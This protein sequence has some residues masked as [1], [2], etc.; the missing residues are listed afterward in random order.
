MIT[1]VDGQSIRSFDELLIYIAMQAKPGQK[2]TL[3]ILRNSSSQ[4]IDV[5]L[6]TR[7]EGLG[8]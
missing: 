2:V 5:Q 1:S 8:Q 6:G 7:A 3:T 4:D